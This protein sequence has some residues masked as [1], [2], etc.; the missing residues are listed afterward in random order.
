MSHK[1]FISYSTKDIKIAEAVCETLEASE[2][3]CWY[4]KQ[5]LTTHLE[6]RDIGVWYSSG[7]LMTASEWSIP[8]KQGIG[9]SRVFIALITTAYMNSGPCLAE[10]MRFCSRFDKDL[11]PPSLFL[12][13]CDLPDRIA[14]PEWLNTLLAQYQ[15]IDISDDR[16]I[17]VLSELL[18]K[19]QT[20]LL[21]RPSKDPMV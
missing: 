2:I 18:A 16:F 1:V 9:E 19:I 11:D 7:V 10:L 13:T 21:L 6:S 5:G 14:R 8:V 4:S 15:Y 17:D 20:A 12:V 3:G